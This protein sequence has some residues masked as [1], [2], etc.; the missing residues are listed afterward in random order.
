MKKETYETLT[1]MIAADPLTKRQMEEISG[2]GDEIVDLKQAARMLGV[3]D[4]TMRTIKI[5]RVRINRY[6]RYRLRDVR[7]YRDQ[8]VY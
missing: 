3:S 6:I 4:N 2:G 7:N 8:H 5:P 1:A